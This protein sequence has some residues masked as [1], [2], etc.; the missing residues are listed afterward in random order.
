MGRLYSAVSSVAVP[1]ATNTALAASMTD[2][3]TGALRSPPAPCRSSAV[4]QR[5]PGTGCS[6][7]I[8]W[9]SARRWSLTMGTTHCKAGSFFSS[10]CAA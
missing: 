5:K 8:A 3:A 7:R 6:A 4:M 10:N 2:H 9:N 1:L